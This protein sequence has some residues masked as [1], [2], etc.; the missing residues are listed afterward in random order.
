MVKYIL[1]VD[2]LLPCPRVVLTE[3]TDLQLNRAENHVRQN[4]Y[5]SI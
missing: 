5:W 3:C 4:I 2:I 1:L